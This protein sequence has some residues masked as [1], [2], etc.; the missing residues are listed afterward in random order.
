MLNNGRGT[1]V[2]DALDLPGG[3]SSNSIFADSEDTV[4]ITAEDQN[5]DGLFD[6]V[7]VNQ[8]DTTSHLLMNDGT[9]GD[10]VDDPLDWRDNVNIYRSS[11]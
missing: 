7:L 6:I 4:F 11:R 8:G 2:E 10:L 3:L 9:A 5:N 1:F